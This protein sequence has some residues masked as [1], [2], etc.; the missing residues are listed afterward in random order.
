MRGMHAR[1]GSAAL[2]LQGLSAAFRQLVHGSGGSMVEL[3]VLEHAPLFQRAMQHADAAGKEMY[4]FEDRERSGGRAAAVLA[5]RPEGTAGGL[6][7]PPIF[8]RYGAAQKLNVVVM[9]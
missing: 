8:D 1:W 6:L 7:L 4:A 5:L 2:R 9:S 3:P